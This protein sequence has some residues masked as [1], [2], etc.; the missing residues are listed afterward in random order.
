M[1]RENSGGSNVP[2][3]RTS[4]SLLVPCLLALPAPAAEAQADGLETADPIVVTATR[5]TLP[6]TA[7][8]LTGT[9]ID[10]AALDRQVQISG[11]VVDAVVALIPSFWPARQKLT[12]Q[13][14]A[15]RGQ[16][17]LFAID[18]IS[19][20]APLRDGSRGG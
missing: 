11:S 5:T 17:P 19:Q 4:H 7:L 12:G 13:G 14:E 20:T 8:P 3:Q 2:F 1:A 18:G 9:V 10:R 15:L 16:S 6:I